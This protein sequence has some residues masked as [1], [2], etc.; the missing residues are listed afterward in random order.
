[1]GA[2]EGGGGGGEGEILDVGLA[3]SRVKGEG[4]DVSASLMAWILAS[5]FFR[6]RSY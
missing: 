1:M 6:C 5:Y 3:V 2:T 4:F